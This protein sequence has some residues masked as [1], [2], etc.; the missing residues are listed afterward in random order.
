L[1]DM[2]SLQDK[3]SFPAPP[4]APAP[5]EPPR[6]LADA[7]HPPEKK[8]WFRVQITERLRRMVKVEAARRGISSSTL[9]TRLLEAEERR[10]AGE[11]PV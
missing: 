11:N 4:D 3:V 7:E 6:L 10:L 9:I 5:G 8:I 2:K 1:N